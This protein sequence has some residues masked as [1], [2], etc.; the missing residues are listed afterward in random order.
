MIIVPKLYLN[1]RQIYF[2]RL[3][4]LCTSKIQEKT[5][6]KMSFA[7]SYYDLINQR[8]YNIC[9]KV[10]SWTS[11]FSN[12]NQVE[13]NFYILSQRVQTGLCEGL[14]PQR[15]HSFVFVFS[16][17]QTRYGKFGVTSCFKVRLYVALN[18]SNRFLICANIQSNFFEKIQSVLNNGKSQTS[19]IRIT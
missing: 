3:Y 1:H 10:L 18:V 15:A 5:Y 19:I 8:Y 14:Y 13:L 12:T 16:V 17:L 2:S 6:D 9:Y 4:V 7:F 11:F